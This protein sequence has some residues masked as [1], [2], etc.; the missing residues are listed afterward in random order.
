MQIDIGL[1]SRGEKVESSALQCSA[2]LVGQ[3][4][5]GECLAHWGPGQPPVM[6]LLA[7]E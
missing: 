2:L 3:G 4:G 5:R 1:T 7:G 6:T